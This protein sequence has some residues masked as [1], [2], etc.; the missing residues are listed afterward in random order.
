MHPRQRYHRV[1]ARLNQR[2]FCKLRSFR[3]GSK[4][5]ASCLQSFQH[6]RCMTER[7]RHGFGSGV[8]LSS[9]S[10][11]A[12]ACVCSI[13]N[14]KGS[15][16]ARDQG[17]L[18]SVSRCGV[19]RSAETEPHA[20]QHC[21]VV[22]IALPCVQLCILSLLGVAMSACAYMSNGRRPYRYVQKL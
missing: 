11:C 7:Q 5:V 2:K 1:P 12:R 18:C 14:R 10:W 19:S 17:F 13:H 9:K 8:V 21:A 16:P 3:R 15:I 22:A 20:H 4:G 6:R